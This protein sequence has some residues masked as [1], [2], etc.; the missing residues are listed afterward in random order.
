VITVKTQIHIPSKNA[1]ERKEIGGLTY[2]GIFSPSAATAESPA[3]GQRATFAEVGFQPGRGK[4]NW[5][6]GS[7]PG[8]N[9]ICPSCGQKIPHEQGMPCRSVKCPNCGNFMIREGIATETG[10]EAMT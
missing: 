1:G 6:P 2:A 7:G 5:K 8:G 9:C 10:K 4:G 3:Q